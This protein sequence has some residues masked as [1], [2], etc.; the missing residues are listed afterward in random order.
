MSDS[1]HSAIE[2]LQADLAAS[3]TRIGKIKADLTQARAE[4]GRLERALKA[5]LNVGEPDGPGARGVTRE[6]LRPLVET[7]LAE[8]PTVG[9]AD[10]YDLVREKL[11]T[12]G[13]SANGLG[14]RLKEILAEQGMP[15]PRDTAFAVGNR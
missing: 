14:L 7:V 2:L 10:V 4:H 15:N 6:L 12:R 1:I 8:N 5:L 9:Y 3:E 11:A 13:L